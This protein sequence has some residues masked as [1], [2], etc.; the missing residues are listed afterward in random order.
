M[1]T[2]TDPRTGA[3]TPTDLEATSAAQADA[4]VEAAQAAFEASS[5]HDR[6]W[7]AG[8]LDAMADA[9]DAHRAEL[10]AVADRETGL[11]T[12][13]LEG[14]VGRSSFQFRLFAEALRDGG[15]LEAAI[16]HAATTPLGAAPDIRRMLVPIG[17]VAVFGSSNFPFAFSVAGGDTASALAAGN[18]VVVKAHSSHLETSART[19]AVLAAAAAEAGAPSGI[20]GIVYG[21]ESGRVLVAHPIIRAVGF[22]GSL[23]GGR[24]LLDLIN[25]RPEPRNKRGKRRRR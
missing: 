15:Y 19:H 3:V 7:R 23:G 22:T 14:E 17:P 4:V 1:L 11:G 16:D 8:L 9:L 21:T 6:L 12:A 24:A 2:S 18:S 25:A 13:R 10:V 20:I 5:A